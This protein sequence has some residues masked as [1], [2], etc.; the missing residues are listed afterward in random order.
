MDNSFFTRHWWKTLQIAG[1]W[2]GDCF[3]WHST[4]AWVL[5]SASGGSMWQA[6]LV[7]ICHTVFSTEI[8]AASARC[9]RFSSQSPVLNGDTVLPWVSSIIFFFV[10]AVQISSFPSYTDRISQHGGI[11]DASPLGY[12]SLQQ[13]GGQ[14]QH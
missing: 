3:V 14:D 2:R 7:C 4:C 13:Y 6:E 8:L 12:V 1:T 10:K 11:C 9:G 5:Y